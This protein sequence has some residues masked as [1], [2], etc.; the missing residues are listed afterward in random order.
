MTPDQRKQ[1]NDE[2]NRGAAADALLKNP[3]FNDAF[4]AIN[5]TIW[6][7]LVKTNVHQTEEIKALITLQKANQKL[8]EYFKHHVQTGRMADIQLRELHSREKR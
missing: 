8:Y 5:R 6:S 4:M 7:Q 1:L 3:M 2:S